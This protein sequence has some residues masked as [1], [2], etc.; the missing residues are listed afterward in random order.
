MLLRARKHRPS[1][2]KEFGNDPAPLLVDN[3]AELRALRWR[4][5]IV[6][7]DI[8]LTAHISHEASREDTA[9]TCMIARA[10]KSKSDA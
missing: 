10:A 5:L 8:G 9:D 3:D 1:A 2:A 4:R 6:E 7:A